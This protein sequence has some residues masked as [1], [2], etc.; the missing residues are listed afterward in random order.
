MHPSR[1]SD[2]RPDYLLILPWNIRE[3][4]ITQNSYIKAWSGRFIVPI[5]KPEIIG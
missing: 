4:V 2:T 1:I 5:P 3:E